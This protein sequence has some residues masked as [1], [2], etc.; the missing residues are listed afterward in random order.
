MY[1]PSHSQMDDMTNEIIYDGFKEKGFIDAITDVTV[2]HRVIKNHVSTEDIDKIIRKSAGCLIQAGKESK[3]D[4]ENDTLIK[5]DDSGRVSPS[6]D[7][8]A[9]VGSSCSS[10][11]D[12]KSEESVK[13]AICKFDDALTD[14]DGDNNNNLD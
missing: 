10:S 8:Q 6:D 11:D 9:K 7:P 14:D 2:L 3:S 13:S 1:Y 4:K 5:H 12:S